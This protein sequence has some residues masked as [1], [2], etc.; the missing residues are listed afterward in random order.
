M[1]ED[2]VLEFG[3]AMAGP[4]KRGT[5]FIK[6]GEL[7]DGSPINMPV[8]I[9]NG[10]NPGPKLMIYCLEDGDEYPGA[11]GALDAANNVLPDMLDEMNGSVVLLPATNISAFRGNRFGG[12]QRNSPLDIDQGARLM[13]LYPGNPYKRHTDQLAYQITKVREEYDPDVVIKTHGCKQMYGWDMVLVQKYAFGSKLDKLCRAAV[14]E[15][16]TRMILML[17]RGEDPEA[18]PLFF[19]LE[20]NGGNNGVGNGFNGDL[21]RDGFINVMRHLKMIPGEEIKIQKIQYFGRR[22]AERDGFE[23]KHIHSTKGGFFK[24][25]VD[26]KDEVKKGQVVA[27]IRNFFGE[28]VEEL[29]ALDDGTVITY[30]YEAP[31][32]GSGQW[33]LV[34]TAIPIAYK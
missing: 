33:R 1:T 30:Y 34:T 32:V 17:E 22:R 9:L 29:K 31:H 4:S 26:V 12:G 20:S 24:P 5:G 15:P 2:R 18:R 11:L 8:I 28:V 25:L 23:V 3:T 19:Q 7:C 27:E 6:V 21:I 16:D 10:R 14:T 13:S